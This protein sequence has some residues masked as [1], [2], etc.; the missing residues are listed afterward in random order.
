MFCIQ[1]NQFKVGTFLYGK[2]VR[3][4]LTTQIYDLFLETSEIS[5][6]FP[7]VGGRGR[8]QHYYI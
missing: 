5:R 3:L 4:I 1:I 6:K 2:Q 7:K 8:E